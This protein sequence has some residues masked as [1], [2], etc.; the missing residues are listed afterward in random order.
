MDEKRQR[1]TQNAAYR[2]H[3]SGAGAADAHR[4]ADSPAAGDRPPRLGEI[5]VA[6]GHISREQ[7]SAALASQQQ[8]GRRLG[9]ELIKAGYVKRAV[10]SRALR[11]QRR[12]VFGAMTTLAASS[13]VPDVGAAAVQS[14]IAVTAIVPAQAVG[15][16]VQEPAEITITDADIARGYVDVP[17]GTRLRVSSNNPTGYFIDFFTRLPI[18]RGVRVSNSSGSA[19]LGPEGGTIVERG[20]PGRNL[21]LDLS[22]RFMLAS[23]VQPGTYAWPLALNVRAL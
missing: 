1:R 20:Q 4:R 17:M 5:L 3:G 14:Q 12:I 13:I 22:Y 6:Q 18:F 7:L 19:D 11:I 10:V 23:S 2:T 8:S 16:V 9:E 15:Q 21:P